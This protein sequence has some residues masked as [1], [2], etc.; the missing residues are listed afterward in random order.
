MIEVHLRRP[1]RKF[2]YDIY[3]INKSPD[4]AVDDV[5]FQPDSDGGGQWVPLMRNVDYPPTIHLDDEMVRA[6]AEAL[7]QEVP[8]QEDGLV[9][10]LQESL[11]DARQ[12]RDQLLKMLR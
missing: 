11:T 6:L 1:E 4:P 9:S 5:L 3:I 2:G 10:V 7:R 8:K 12:V